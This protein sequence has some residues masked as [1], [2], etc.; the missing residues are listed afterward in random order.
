MNMRQKLKRYYRLDRQHKKSEQELQAL[1]REILTYSIGK[2]KVRDG[3]VIS[4]PL[5]IIRIPGITDFRIIRVDPESTTIDIEKLKQLK[6]RIKIK[7]KTPP[8]VI[9]AVADLINVQVVTTESVNEAAL[10]ELLQRRVF[11][12]KQVDAIISTTP[13]TSYVRIVSA[14]QEEE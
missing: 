6:D 13:R 14:E 2:K 5:R 1:R 11:S 9:Q 10:E 12:Q 4:D 7:K 3:R 8:E